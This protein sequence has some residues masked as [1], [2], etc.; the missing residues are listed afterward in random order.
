MYKLPNPVGANPMFAPKKR[1]VKD[2]RMFIVTKAV[3]QQERPEEI[4]KK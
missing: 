1:E 2:L 4:S 3:S